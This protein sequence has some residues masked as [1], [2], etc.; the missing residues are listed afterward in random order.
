MSEQLSQA[1]EQDGEPPS[2]CPERR[3]SWNDPYYGCVDNEYL[4]LVRHCRDRESEDED[5]LPAEVKDLPR[6]TLPMRLLAIVLGRA[7]APSG[8]E[9]KTTLQ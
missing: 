7:V 4:E 3:R 6:L 2:R 9:Q 8:S 1:D 5:P